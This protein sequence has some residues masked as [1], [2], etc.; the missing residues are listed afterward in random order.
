MTQDIVIEKEYKFKDCK[1]KRPLPFDFAVF[2][3]YNK[4]IGL[5][6]FQCRFNTLLEIERDKQHYN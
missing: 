2:D 3:D 6:E 1:H 5:I 4:I